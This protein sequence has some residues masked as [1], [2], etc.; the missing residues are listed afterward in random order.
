[1]HFSL[2]LRSFLSFL[3]VVA[4]ILVAAGSIQGARTSWR[5]DAALIKR[6]ATSGITTDFQVYEPVLTP[7]EPSNQYG[8]IYTR[9]LMQHSFANSYGAPFIGSYTPPPCDFNRVNINL[10]VTAAGT[11]F[12]R[13]GSLYLGDIEVFRTSTAEPTLEGI[14]W[15]YAKEMEQY[16]AL[17]HANQKIIFDLPNIVNDAYTAAYETKLTATF[18]TVPNSMPIADVIL[19]IS[20]LQSSMNKASA[21]QIPG[22][23]ASVSYTLPPNINRAVVSL[24]A[25]G[26]STEEFWY[27]D[28]LSSDEH[29]FVETGALYGRSPFREVQLFIDGRL[30]G[31]SW[32]FPVIFTGGIVPGFW[33][34]IVGIDAFDI[35]EQEIDITPWLPTLCDGNS[36][37]FELRV[38][39]LSS[40]G[41]GNA[42]LDETVGSY[43]IV[44]GK[45]FVFLDT[46]G[47]T[48]TGTPVTINTPLPQLVVSSS[49]TQ[50]S[51]G[52]NQTLTYLVSA[53]RELSITSTITTSA[54]PRSVFWIQ[55]LSYTNSG[56]YTDQGATQIVSQNTT[57]KDI[58][59][60]GYS[61]D[62]HYPITLTTS[63]FVDASGFSQSNGT[64]NR[65]LDL[66]IWGPSIFPSGVQTFHITTP[67]TLNIYPS[68][69]QPFQVPPSLPNFSGSLLSTT[70]TATALYASTVNGSLN[71]GSTTQNFSFSGAEVGSLDTTELYTRH[72]RVVNGTV[73]QD[74]QSLVGQTFA[75]PIMDAG[76]ASLLPAFTGFT[77]KSILGRGPGLSK[78]ELGGSLGPS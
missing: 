34:P 19:P 10:T 6:N 33:Q 59:S 56:S 69:S 30:A 60:S 40:D 65:G 35:R 22:V 17:W 61:R 23:N 74:Q 24:L 54:G 28:V 44:S 31:V 46:V 7:I 36:H 15:T 70:Q 62:Y 53:T 50:N 55:H 1:M 25:N 49:V 64:I 73:V 38:A 77:V 57:G 12:D 45:I 76:E 43:W 72:V 58:S 71:I 66:D 3:A 41:T 14:T 67:N 75:E 4:R 32:P 51:K 29:T 47:S 42:S 13:L 5:P 21:F 8:C 39:G 26:Q 27:T 78:A 48:T 11:Q 9:V 52:S 20:S 18:F 63:F 2:P 37:N 68:I 16:N